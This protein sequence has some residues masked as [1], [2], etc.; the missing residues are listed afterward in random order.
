MHFQ[1]PGGDVQD[2]QDLPLGSI[3]ESLAA[4]MPS[5]H[6]RGLTS[7]PGCIII[8]LEMLQHC[9]GGNSLE[10]SQQ[11]ESLASL[12]MDAIRAHMPACE[13][14]ADITVAVRCHAW[15][16]SILVSCRSLT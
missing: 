9:R 2:E 6:I 7:R 15:T 13:G 10:P 5:F 4:R 12:A 3:R 11:W 16:S 8:E 14:G 1:I